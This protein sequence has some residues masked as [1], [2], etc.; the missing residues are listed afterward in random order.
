MKLFIPFHPPKSFLPQPNLLH[1][2]SHEKAPHRHLIR[3][4]II[5]QS[6]QMLSSEIHPQLFV[7]R[8]NFP[9]TGI[10]QWLRTA[11]IL[12]QKWLWNIW[13]Y[14]ESLYWLRTSRWPCWTFPRLYRMIF[15]YLNFLP[16]IFSLLQVKST[17]GTNNSS[18]LSSLAHHLLHR[19]LC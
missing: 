12:R 19:C 16:S 11:R 15:F 7:K 4:S 17:P 18:I 3:G 2:G 9:Q 8:Q 5:D 13:D 10:I 1:N 6:P 14:S